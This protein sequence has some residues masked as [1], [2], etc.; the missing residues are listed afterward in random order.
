MSV[1]SIVHR[2][3]GRAVENR[4]IAVEYVLCED[5]VAVLGDSHWVWGEDSSGCIKELTLMRYKYIF[6][7]AKF[8]DTV[9]DHLQRGPFIT[10]IRL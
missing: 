9:V 1:V 6:A 7:C 2:V 10:R 5:R 3:H 8:S 4:I